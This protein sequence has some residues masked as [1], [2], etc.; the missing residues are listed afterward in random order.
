MTVLERA[1]SA[2]LV[3]DI[4]LPFALIGL[5]ATLHLLYVLRRWR[6]FFVGSV[7]IVLLLLSA[8]MY[9]GHLF[10]GLLPVVQK[11]SLAACLGWL[12]A[13]NYV[14]FSPES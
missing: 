2:E 4:V 11:A 12:L 1:A 8:A 7:G 3:D 13:V 6:L 9:Y 14:T 5:L 10:F